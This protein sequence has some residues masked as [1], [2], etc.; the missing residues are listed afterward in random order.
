MKMKKLRAKLNQK[1]LAQKMVV[2]QL[3]ARKAASNLSLAA[4]SLLH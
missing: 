1:E 2:F 3:K 4:S